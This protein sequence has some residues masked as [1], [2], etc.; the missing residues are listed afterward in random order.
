MHGDQQ[1]PRP[2]TATL[3]VKSRLDALLRETG[4]SNPW[5][6]EQLN[7]SVPTVSNWRR[8]HA[9]PEHRH[10]AVAEIF[11]GL[12]EREVTVEEVSA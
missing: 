9:I 6:A 11:N 10:E 12:L 5:L 3:P 8:G 4:K 1:A 7:V 2:L